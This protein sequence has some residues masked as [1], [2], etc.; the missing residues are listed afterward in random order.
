MTLVEELGEPVAPPTPIESHKLKRMPA[1]CRGYADVYNPNFLRQMVA[2][3]V[4]SFNFFLGQGMK[5]VIKHARPHIFS[6][7]DKG[8]F[9][10]SIK[11]VEIGV[12]VMFDERLTP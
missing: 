4:E 1:R 3:H 6:L 11:H 2:P 7:G 5:N 8:V 12:P 9:S 10:L